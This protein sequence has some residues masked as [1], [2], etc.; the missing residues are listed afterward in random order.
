MMTDDTGDTTHTQ[1]T[2]AKCPVAWCPFCLAVSTV[3]PVAPG[4]VEH[5]LK[6]GTEMFLAFRSII[7]ARGK[8]LDGTKAAEPVRLEKIDVG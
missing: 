3:R 4:T 6:A 8:D 7:E 1:R 5:L 2:S